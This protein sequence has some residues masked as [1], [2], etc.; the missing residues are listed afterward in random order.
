MGHRLDTVVARRFPSLSRSY[1]GQLIRQARVTVNGRP[2]KGAYLLRKADRVD[3]DI[4][5]LPTP[6]LLPPEPIPLHVLFEDTH[7]LAVN[8]PPGMVVHPAPGH[9]TGTLVNALLH[10]CPSIRTV[11]TPTRPGIV[12]RLDK[13]TSGTLVVAKTMLAYDALTRQFKERQV[14]KDYLALVYG[15]FEEMAG[16]VE[17]PVGRHPVDRKKMSTVSPRGRPAETEWHVRNVL[18]AVTLLDVRIHT[19]RTHQIRVHCASMGHPVVGDRRY[20]GKK[21]WKNIPS[22]AARI[23]LKAVTRQMLHARRL[24]CT[25]PETGESMAFE[26]PLPKDM[27]DLIQA[28]ESTV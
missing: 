4:P 25:H 7:V 20:G 2:R 18:G 10:R 3:C 26:S 8:K 23:R 22:A 21:G 11:G 16:H 15:R 27:D 24:T 9:T 6:S 28:L 17:A 1:A 12:H 19:G 14:R 13:D 5:A